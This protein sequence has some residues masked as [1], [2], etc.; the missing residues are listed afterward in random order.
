MSVV[1]ESQDGLAQTVTVGEHQLVADEPVDAGGKDAGPG[2][3]D[4]LLSALGTCTSMTIT[5]YARRKKWPL[6]GVRVE[7]DHSRVHVRDC[8]QCDDGECDDAE[9]T[10][11]EYI[12]KRVTVRGPLSEE[13]RAKLAEI[14]TRC[15]VERT[16]LGN[17][18]IDG[19]VKLA[20]TTP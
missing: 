15:P 12:R 2:P 3:Y 4:L 16:L 6:E 14:S 1:V 13:Q 10:R 18:R 9:K 17:I 19:E 11:L 5:L 8:E 7:L 20:A